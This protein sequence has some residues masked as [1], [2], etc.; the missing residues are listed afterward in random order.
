MAAGGLRDLDSGVAVGDDG[1]A[2]AGR[3]RAARGGGTEGERGGSRGA[4]GG[5]GRVSV[6]GCDGGGMNR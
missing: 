5:Y 3:A 1:E 2:G 4:G 6:R